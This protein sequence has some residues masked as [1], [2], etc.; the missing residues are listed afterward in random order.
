MEPQYIL[1]IVVVVVLGIIAL[2]VVLRYRRSSIRLKVPGGE[3]EAEG[4]QDSQQPAS[5]QSASGS[6][7]TKIGGKLTGSTVITSAGGGGQAETEVD[8]DV[9]QSDILTETKK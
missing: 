6:A 7:R 5:S 9:E 4:E 2:A 1:Y 8:Q 3:L